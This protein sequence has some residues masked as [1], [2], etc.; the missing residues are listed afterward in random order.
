MI[1]NGAVDVAG[2]SVSDRSGKSGFDFAGLPVLGEDA[3]IV[4]RRSSLPLKGA[5]NCEVV[6]KGKE[7]P[8]VARSW[9]IIVNCT[10]VVAV[11]PVIGQC[12]H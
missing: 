5:Y 7:L 6:V 4:Q 1:K 9:A 8:T 11:K 2:W 3:E 10:A 12:F